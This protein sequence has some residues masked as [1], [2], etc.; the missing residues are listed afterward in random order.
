MYFAGKTDPVN[1]NS[2]TKMAWSVAQKYLEKTYGDKLGNSEHNATVVT[3]ETAFGIQMDIDGYESDVW[4]PLTNGDVY[5][6]SN[7]DAEFCIYNFCT[8]MHFS[9]KYILSFKDTKPV[10]SKINYREE[11]HQSKD[12]F[13]FLLGCVGAAG[14]TAPYI[15]EISG[16]FDAL[17]EKDAS[18]FDDSAA[19]VAIPNEDTPGETAGR[20]DIVGEDTPADAAT[21][22]LEEFDSEPIGDVLLEDSYETY[23]EVS[24]DISDQGSEEIYVEPYVLDGVY[25]CFESTDCDTEPLF[26]CIALEGLVLADDTIEEFSDYSAFVNPA[27]DTELTFWSPGLGLMLFTQADEPDGVSGSW[28][29]ETLEWKDLGFEGPLTGAMN[30][31]YIPEFNTFDLNFYSNELN[32][33]GENCKHYFLNCDKENCEE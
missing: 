2:K 26:G 10:L 1:P 5:I 25:L 28:Q 4:I 6:E 33:S 19:E 32:S 29:W 21:D 12:G 15:G 18:T 22:I 11:F 8:P 31:V 23:P 13:P 16:G 20:T 24:E 17:Y 3:D 7:F 27:S 9:E 30:L 14:V